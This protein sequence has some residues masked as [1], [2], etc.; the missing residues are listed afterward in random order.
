MA[1]AAG[2]DASSGAGADPSYWRSLRYFALARLVVAAVLVAWVSVLRGTEGAA[3]AFDARGFLATAVAYLAAAAAFV[4]L[5]RPG[6]RRLQ[7]LAIAQVAV[8]VLALSLLGHFAGGLRSGLPI[9]LI[10]PNAGAAILLGTRLA[11]FFAAV[12]TLALLVE[13]GWR[14]LEGEI[15]DPAT[16]QAG[17]VGA[18]LLGT[19]WTV[20]RLAQRLGAQERLARRRGEDLRAQLAITQAVIG[21]LPDGV[22]VLSEDGEPRA[23]NRAAREML[24]AG[25]DG[26]P[27]AAGLWALRAAIGLPR[28][29]E[30]PDAA[31]DR[32]ARGDG[33]EFAIPPGGAVGARRIRAR[34]LG[35]AVAGADA[36]V[37][38]EDLGRIEARAQQL[39]LASMGRLSASI[40]HEIRNPL[41]AIR[42]ANGLLAERLDDAS[43]QR[44]AQIV[45][46]NCRR[47]DRIVE[48]V[49]SISR[50]GRAAPEALPAGAFVERTLA[51]YVAQSGTDAARIA[52]R[53]AIDDPIWFD[54]GNLRQVLLNL[55][56]NALRHAS[57]APGAVSIEWDRDAAGRPVLAVADD[58]PG[59]PAESQVH[60]FEPFFTTDPRGT[61]LGLHLARELCAANGASIRYRPAGGD[62]PFRSAF[63]V[64]PAPLPAHCAP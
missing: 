53:V 21:E 31:P 62:P 50:R 49:L 28:P 32:I 56:A 10:L 37:V 36:V 7:P 61:G 39:K 23:I 38:M 29:G 48:D 47:I 11:L 40:A 63:L 45:E 19:A 43:L 30:A 20:A 34:R 41:S 33:V 35:A 4:P 44:M 60:L 24:G 18:A 8:D 25:A 3:D 6:G 57:A 51:E 64:E 22:V 13:T 17:L 55:L 1:A 14:R 16:V 5:S 59:V 54:A 15:G 9:L 12:S 27:S 26:A 46:Q 58:G 42:H 52:C 2:S